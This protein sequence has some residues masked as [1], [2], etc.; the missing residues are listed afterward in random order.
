MDL[1]FCLLSSYVFSGLF[2]SLNGKFLQKTFSNTALSLSFVLPRVRLYGSYLG[3]HLIPPDL[4]E[5]ND[6]FCRV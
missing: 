4:Q 1:Y 5:N 6:I 2:V 3:F